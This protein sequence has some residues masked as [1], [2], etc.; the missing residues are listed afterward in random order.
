MKLNATQLAAVKQQTGADPI[1]D[2]SD[3]HGQL[4]EAFGDHTFY[5]SEVGLLVPESV[6]ADGADPVEL[7]LVAEWTD[8]KR[9]AME[10]IPPKQTG[11]VLDAGAASEA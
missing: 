3:A 7:I 5:V 1:E 11:Y 8:E 4:S 10:R 9:E 2:G 6:E